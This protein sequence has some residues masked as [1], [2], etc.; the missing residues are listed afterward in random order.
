MDEW[1]Q[2]VAFGA[3]CLTLKGND[4]ATSEIMNG[5]DPD[6]EKQIGTGQLG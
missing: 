1:E 2:R 5:Q 4:E 3:F 6:K